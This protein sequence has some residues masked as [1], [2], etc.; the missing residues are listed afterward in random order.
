MLTA[1]D[2]ALLGRFEPILRFNKG[3]QF[4]PMDVDHYIGAS[5]LCVKRPD[6]PPQVLVP[7]GRLTPELLATP[8]PDT[9]EAI[10]FLHFV[11]PLPPAQVLQFRRTSS[12]RE[13]RVGSG[14]L[15]RVGLLARLGDLLFNVSLLLR[16]KAPGGAAAAAGLR[17]Q[18]LVSAEPRHVYYGRVV[19][20]HGYIALQYWF[21]YAYN[22]WRSSFHGVNDHEADWELVTVY[23]AEGED[24]TL[25][26]CWLACSC[27]EFRGGDLRRRWDDP[28]L[29]LVG[30]HPVVYV[31][32]GAHANYFARGEYLPG[33]EVPFTGRVLRAWRD[34]RRFWMTILR[35]E[36]ESQGRDAIPG[37]IQIP[38]VD[39]AR[40]DGVAIGPGQP[41]T[42][43]QRLL[44]PTEGQPAP[45]W[46]DGYRGLWGLYTGDLLEGEDAP[47]RPRYNRDG[48]V[49]EMWHDPVGWVGLSRVPPPAA[50]RG[51]LE[52]QQRRLLV[53]QEE[54]ADRIREM[55]ARL[56]GLEMEYEVIRER[57]ELRLRMAETRRE[58]AAGALELRRLKA[59]RASNE[60]VLEAFAGRLA[61]P[62][63]GM[64]GS[65]RAHLR[66]PQ[67]PT[68]A[69]DT[70]VGRLAEAWSAASIGVLLLG[71]VVVAQ[72]SDDWPIALLL[73]VAIY[74]FLESLFRRQVQILLRRGAVALAV[75]T[76]LLILFQFFRPVAVTLLV[77]SGVLVII[78]NLRELRTG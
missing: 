22:D 29:D 24:G 8:R 43:E 5:A 27:H 72:F 26:P 32:A 78:D 33:A 46:V 30:D 25:R 55:A 15:A 51:A 44:Q 70:R 39:Y 3:E 38:F 1:E 53:E 42:W 57:P 11:D 16:G 23:A 49:N 9:P 63:A 12:L 67:V 62:V 77:L 37:I 2:I 4:Y 20:E 73:L 6:E 68:P 66:A 61:V 64:L 71:I 18:E 74:A 65:P 28:S 60:H 7:R 50:T 14:R 21:F 35:L 13:F 36:D 47:A 75:I 69:T 52:S 56:S 41:L 34:V 17:Y 58:I 48:T 40:G 19:R 76:L 10:Y 45:P 54:L 31:A 59:R